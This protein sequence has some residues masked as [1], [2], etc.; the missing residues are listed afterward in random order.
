M[1]AE[2]FYVGLTKSYY[3]MKIY[4]CL[5]FV[6]LFAITACKK[7]NQPA[8]RKFTDV[9]AVGISTPYNDGHQLGTFWKN[10]AVNTITSTTSNGAAN[11]IALQGNNVY[12]ITYSGQDN[13]YSSVC[14]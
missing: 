9:Y 12:M 10:G 2:V 7:S 6:T 11:A 13:N 14:W 8:P 5:L 4:T 1:L 3:V